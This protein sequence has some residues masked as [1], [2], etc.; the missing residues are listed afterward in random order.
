[1]ELITED[2]LHMRTL[3]ALLESTRRRR[4]TNIRALSN[5]LIDLHATGEAGTLI[6]DIFSS[7]EEFT[8]WFN[9]ARRFAGSQRVAT[10]EGSSH[11][12]LEE[13]ASRTGPSHVTRPSSLSTPCGSPSL[14]TSPMRPITA[15]QPDA[16]A[17]SIVPQKEEYDV[18]EL[19]ND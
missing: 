1:M 14:Q 17:S 4:D 6:G 2:A 8:S 5:A 18:D 7:Q 19:Y 9:F 15:Q 12:D 10:P 16:Q 13:L 11:V 3:S